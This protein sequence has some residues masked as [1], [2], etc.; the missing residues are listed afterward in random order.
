MEK[1]KESVM[2]MSKARKIARKKEIEQMKRNAII[3]KVVSIC[4][5]AVLCVGLVSYIGYSIHRKATQVTASSNF[6]AQLNDKGFIDGVDASSLLNLVDYKTIK[7]PLSEIEYSDE[8]VA[9]D[10]ATAVEA[11]KTLN[12]ETDAAIADGNIVNID[13]VG[14]IDGKEFDGGNTNDNGYELKI[15]SKKL[16]DDFE[17]QLIGHKIGDEVTVNVTFPEDYTNKDLAGKDAEFKVKI[18]GIYD[19]PEFT[20]AFVKEN[21][22]EYASNVEEYK[23]YL[24]DTNYAST[25]NTYIVSYLA[26]NTTVTSYPEKYVKLSKSLLK[27]SD[28]SY[29]NSMNQ[30]YM[31]NLGAPA[32]NSFEEY[33]GV[34]EAEYDK[35]LAEPAEKQVKAALIYQAILEK[36]GVTVTADDYIAYLESQGQTKEDFDNQVETYGKNFVLQEMVKIKALELVK[37]MVTV[38]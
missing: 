25:L 11:K 28:Q 23:K 22:S 1:E 21:L 2:S 24:K 31:E 4:V 5:V 9:K 37:G 27:F 33:T 17:E 12:K 36:E 6:S 14:T 32:Y 3:S 35:S 29:Y 13:Y 30:Y 38:E 20:D 19:V 16:V 18:N 7:A 10:I 26:D 34:S 15:G 8:S